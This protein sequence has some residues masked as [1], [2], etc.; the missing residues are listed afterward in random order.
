MN[1]YRV[2]LMVGVLM[3]SGCNRSGNDTVGTL[4]VRSGG[5][6]VFDIK[7]PSRLVDKNG[8]SYVDKGHFSMLVQT[9]DKHGNPVGN[10]KRESIKSALYE[11]GS[12]VPSDESK[13]QFVP[14]QRE[15]TNQIALLLDFSESLIA[16]CGSV[17]A[18][19]DD[20]KKEENLC[21]QL[22]ESAKQFVD[23]TVNE[24]QTMA[25][26][27]FNSKTNITPL[28][29]SNT[30]GATSDKTALKLGLEQL[31]NSSFRAENL[32]G[33]TSTNLYGAVIEVTKVACQWVGSCNY[34][35][36]T[37]QT[38]TNLEH[39]EFASIVVFTDGKDLAHRVSESEMLSFINKHD[40]L[41][42]YT[43]GLGNVDK[44]VLKAI[45]K[46]KYIPV[47][48]N[49][50]LDG[51]FD[52]LSLQLNSWGNSFYKVEYC[53]AAQEGNVDIKI[54]ASDGNYHGIIK[55]RIRMPENV[56]FRCD[57]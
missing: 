15:T 26:Y 27:Y 10:I 7:S 13:V 57:L 51:A 38:N 2:C 24:Q 14:S 45:G 3:L 43:I 37:P 40:S 32:E 4:G 31:Y 52:D 17:N 55:D 19:T 35:I 47:G 9:K 42:Y 11:N 21:Y 16:D 49:S 56:D 36:Y 54:E 29:T 20:A 22:V 41:F 30:A 39:F 23:D 25:I 5:E 33:Y 46:D 1:I 12:N 50:E 53:P 44:N 18:I 48:K 28:V 8:N 6:I 34:D